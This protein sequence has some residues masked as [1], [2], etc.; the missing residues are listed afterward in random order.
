MKTLQISSLVA[1]FSSALLCLVLSGC[2]SAPAV[3]PTAFVEYNAS[4]GTF[5]LEYPEEW[6]EDGGGKHGPVWAKF[7]AGAAEIR[8]NGD[9]VGSLLGDIAGNTA[10]NQDEVSPELQAV[11]KV[12]EMG[13]ED[14]AA[15]F[16]GYEEIGEPV[17]LIVPLGPARKSEFKSTAAFGSGLHGYRVTILGKDKRVVV[18]TVCPE[19]DWATLQPAYDHVLKSLKRGRA[20]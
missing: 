6:S 10:P 15:E 19:S 20:E 17:E 16:S 3:A 1:T 12:H 4:D 7:K 11:H 13:A 14:A 18:F 8:V 5:A 2:G 9:V